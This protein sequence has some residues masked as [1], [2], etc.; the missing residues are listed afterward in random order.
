MKASN[1]VLKVDRDLTI[2][3][4]LQLFRQKKDESMKEN[5]CPAHK[6]VPT[7]R[8]PTI[9]SNIPRSSNAEIIPLERRKSFANTAKSANQS[10]P[11]SKI[12][13]CTSK[14]QATISGCNAKV[15][16][17][18]ALPKERVVIAKTRI[19]TPSEFRGKLDEYTMLAQT[20]GIEI[21]RSFIETVPSESNMKDV[22][23]QVLYWL[24]WIRQESEA[25]EWEYVTTLFSRSKDFVKS[26]SGIQAIKTA[27]EKFLSQHPTVVL[28]IT[29]VPLRRGGRESIW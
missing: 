22:Q 23:S 13:A 4:K 20:A 25:A 24:T 9:T 17:A 14:G 3:E 12:A 6:S 5:D 7:R 26:L 1:D 16:V 28:P 8:P 18:P 27:E 11:T 29:G 2:S 15:I 19:P 21:A 10:I